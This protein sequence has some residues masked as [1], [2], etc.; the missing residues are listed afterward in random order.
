[1][2]K[3][4]C[5]IIKCITYMYAFEDCNVKQDGKEVFDYWLKY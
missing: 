1:M 3:E 4:N 2:L 5:V